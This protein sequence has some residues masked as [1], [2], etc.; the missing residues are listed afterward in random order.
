M[1]SQQHRKNHNKYPAN[2][3]VMCFNVVILFQKKISDSKAIA[4]IFKAWITKLS[5]I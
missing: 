1:G 3:L 4:L 5:F 2:K